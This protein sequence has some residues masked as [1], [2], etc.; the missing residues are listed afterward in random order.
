MID[1]VGALQHLYGIDSHFRQVIT[2]MVLMLSSDNSGFIRSIYDYSGTD[3]MI[4]QTS[5]SN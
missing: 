2:Y 3:T 4:F 5:Y 1:D